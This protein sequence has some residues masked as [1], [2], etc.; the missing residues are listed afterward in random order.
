MGNYFETKNILPIIGY[1]SVIS[2]MITHAHSHIP[3]RPLAINESY[4]Q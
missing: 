4:S 1:F 3:S 2:Q